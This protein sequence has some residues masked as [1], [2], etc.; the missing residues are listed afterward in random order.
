MDPTTPEPDDA[1]DSLLRDAAPRAPRGFADGVMRHVDVAAGERRRLQARIAS[2]GALV[3]VAAAL[4]L[5]LVRPTTE[6][7]LPPSGWS[8]VAQAGLTMTAPDGRPAREPD[9]GVQL[10]VAH[11]GA[12]TLERALARV[13]LAE[14]SRLRVADGGALQ[15]STGGARLE[16]PETRIDGDVATVTT[17]GVSADIAVRLERRTNMN[18]KNVMSATLATVMTVAAHGGGALV[19]AHEHAPVLLA[20]N[21]RATMV[22]NLPPLVNRAPVLLAKNDVKVTPAAKPAAQ[23]EAKPAVSR[24][25]AGA[26]DTQPPVGEE[27]RDKIRAVMRSASADLKSCYETALAKTPDLYG[28]VRVKMTLLNR[29]G[30]AVVDEAEVM[31]TGEGDLVAPLF[32]QCIIGVVGKLQFPTF[33]SDD[34]KLVVEYPFIF[35]ADPKD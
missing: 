9:V 32:E 35:K 25:G 16:G 34:G 19:Q 31:P 27:D 26:A 28:R 6:V 18:A 23:T 4:V 11:G 2:V 10:A 20:Q 15:L 5:W 14:D 1:I 30:K 3:A 12:A 8:V 13:T 21:D 22:G 17:L 33:Q 24:K 29:D 7:H